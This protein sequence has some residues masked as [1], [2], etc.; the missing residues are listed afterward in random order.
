MVSPD[1]GAFDRVLLP[2]NCLKEEEVFLDDRTRSDM[3]RRL[4]VPVQIGWDATD[5][6][7]AKNAARAP[8]TSGD[9]NARSRA[10]GN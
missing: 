7:D 2:P 8:R 3:E 1:H 4:G 10:A 6:T 5:A 9:T